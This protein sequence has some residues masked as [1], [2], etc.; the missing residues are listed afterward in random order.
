MI[1]LRR[2]TPDDTALY[3]QECALRERVLL[4]AV[5]FTFERYRD[6]YPHED[7]CEHWVAVTAHPSSGDTVLGCAL[8]MPGTPDDKSAKVS[9]VAV[10][11]QRQG[12]GI[13]RR[14]MIA[15][16]SRAFGELG[17]D[18]LFCHAQMPAVPFYER[19]GWTPVGEM[20][21]EAG[22]EHRRME[23][24]RERL[25]SQASSA[26]DSHLPDDGT[27]PHGV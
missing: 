23:L 5:G 20:F 4:S 27:P 21:V 16:E 24:N 25:E 19:L 18:R 9:Q 8:L 14:L 2:I 15:V 3:E 26:A 17:L 11:R 13:G 7:A 6:E 12:E 10:N 22:I 1:R